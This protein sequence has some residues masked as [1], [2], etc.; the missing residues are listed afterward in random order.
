MVY[1]VTF[2]RRKGIFLKLCIL[3]LTCI[4]FS[5]KME[6]YILYV[7]KAYKISIHIYIARLFAKEITTLYIFVFFLSFFLFHAYLYTVYS[8]ALQYLPMSS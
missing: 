4:P 1:F 3:F 8:L 5:W 7:C 2:Y 6:K